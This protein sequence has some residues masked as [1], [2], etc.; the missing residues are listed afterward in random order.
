MRGGGGMVSFRVAGGIDGARRFLDA[1]RLVPI[2]TSLGGVETVVEI[3]YE[4]DFGADELGLSANDSGVDPGLIRLSVGCEDVDD[5]LADL[6]RGLAA[7][8]GRSAETSAAAAGR[9]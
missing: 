6:D 9:P 1:L 5:L 7:I 4:L 2:A 8:A 3:P